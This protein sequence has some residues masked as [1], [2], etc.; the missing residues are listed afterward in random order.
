M[1]RVW[2]LALG[3]LL[4][5]S[6]AFAQANRRAETR[7]FVFAAPGVITGFSDATVIHFGGGVEAV[8]ACGFGFAL[9]AGY[10]AEPDRFK[11]GLGSASAAAIYQFRREGRA[12]PYIRAGGG[13][14][15]GAYGGAAFWNIGAG[16]NYWFEDRKGLK[17]EVRDTFDSTGPRYGLFEVAFGLVFKF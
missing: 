6:P 1:R 10:L 4:F 5:A 11:S 15:V 2:I 3:V 16:L 14:L 17:V 9:D 13:W 7:A 12:Q 8:A